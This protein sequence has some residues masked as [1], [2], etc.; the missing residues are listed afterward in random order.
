MTQDTQKKWK[1]KIEEILPTFSERQIL[2]MED[3]DK[4]LARE[5]NMNYFFDKK[6]EDSQNSQDQIPASARI[7]EKTDNATARDLERYE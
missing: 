5:N 1:E 6:N 7:I 2:L 4:R 3:K